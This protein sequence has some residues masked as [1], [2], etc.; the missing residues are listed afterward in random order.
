MGAVAALTAGAVLLAGCTG[1]DAPAAGPP[2]T[3]TTSTTSNASTTSTVPQLRAAA[4]PPC[5]TGATG[6][7]TLPDWVT[8]PLPPGTALTHGNTGVVVPAG[9][10]P[11]PFVTVL[12][13]PKDGEQVPTISLYRTP[14]ATSTNVEWDPSVATLGT[15]RGRPGTVGRTISRGGLGPTTAVWQ[16]GG[17]SWTATSSLGSAALVGA[18]DRL[19]LSPDGATDPTGSF[20]QVGTGPQFTT[21]TAR[22]TQLQVRTTASSPADERV[23]YARIDRAAPGTT[24]PLQLP[25]GGVAAATRVDGRVV[26]RNPFAATSTTADGAQVEVRA[27]DGAS[28]PASLDPAT[29]TAVLAG[30][31]RRGPA[32]AAAVDSL[33]L[34]D[35]DPGGAVPEGFCR[36]S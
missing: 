8:G 34:G 28:R 20:A 18:L 5:A 19:S 1:T 17:A 21:S 16:E 23:L 6:I 22:S 12:V 35:L 30:L 29:L 7:T 13:G 2:T 25:A 15:V 24:G 27:Y 4:L 9:G 3:S 14:G 36:E 26:L 10:V 32:D 31:H 33:S 11:V